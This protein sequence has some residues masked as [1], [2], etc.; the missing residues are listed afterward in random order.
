VARALDEAR[1]R[2]LNPDDASEAE[3]KRRTLTN[4]SSARPTWL[5]NLHRDLDRAVWVAYGGEDDPAVTSD[6]ATLARLLAL[7][8]PGRPDR[9]RR[10]IGMPGVPRGRRLSDGERLH[11]VCVQ[12]GGRLRADDAA[13]RDMLPG[14]SLLGRR[15]RGRLRHS[16]GLPGALRLLGGLS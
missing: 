12:H 14:G 8:L 6:E 7:P 10:R 15:V 2:W 4:L 5:A 1:R 13:R 9:H 11:F 16:G 3:L